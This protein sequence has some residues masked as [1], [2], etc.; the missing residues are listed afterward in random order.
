MP[1]RR[2]LL[3]TLG[4]SAT[5]AC[6]PEVAAPTAF[7]P[8]PVPTTMRIID[9]DLQGPNVGR[10]DHDADSTAIAAALAQVNRA[11]DR[12]VGLRFGSAN[13]LLTQSIV[14]TRPDVSVFGPGSGY[15]KLTAHP[16]ARF[17]KMVEAVNAR[18]LIWEGLALDVNG[19]ARPVQPDPY[20]GLVLTRCHDSLITDL[21]VHRALGYPETPT[22]P[23]AHANACSAAESDRVTMRR[24]AC[25]DSPVAD[26]FYIMGRD[27]VIEDIEGTGWGDTLAVLEGASNG[28]IRRVR[29]SYG[30]ALWAVS[31]F[32]NADHANNLVDDVD[33]FR[34]NAYS[35][36]GRIATLGTAGGKLLGTRVRNV[37]MRHCAGPG[38]HVHEAPTSPGYIDDLHFEDVVLEDCLT[39][40]MLMDGG[41]RVR[42]AVTIRRP[43]AS[44]AQ[45]R[46]RAQDVDLT[47]DLETAQ[48]V[49][50]TVEGRPDVTWRGQVRAIGTGMSWGAY[51]YGICPRAREQ[52][53]VTGWRNGPVGADAGTV[54]ARPA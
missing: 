4:A 11:P 23:A 49:G 40:G 44:G 16:T 13:Y 14:I 53:A 48:Q 31:N 51:F 26:G 21:V 6:H 36:G 46:A 30:G 28:I 7:P 41:R 35:G 15:G 47:V 29:G 25:Y 12:R 27:G 8:P 17:P 52:L 19:R 9:V 50:L 38:I 5:A 42:G 20:S 3:W 18:G 37:R 43:G 2:Q 39:Q 22:R 10:G 24:S 32:T 54:V 34:L 45:V 1:T 33:G